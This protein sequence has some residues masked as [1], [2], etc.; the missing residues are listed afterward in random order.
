MEGQPTGDHQYFYNLDAYLH[1]VDEVRSWAS[2]CHRARHH[3]DRRFSKLR[4]FPTPAAP[5]IPR[6]MRKTFESY[7]DDSDAIRAFGLD[8]VTGCATSCSPRGLARPAFLQH[9]HGRPDHR[10]LPAT[11][12]D[13]LISGERGRGSSAPAVTLWLKAGACRP[14]I[15]HRPA[16][17]GRPPHLRRH[18]NPPPCESR[19][20]LPAPAV[21]SAGY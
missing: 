14:Q 1:F 5:R 20:S 12:A 13:C 17:F 19:S 11:G 2:R 16:I 6:W 4:V 10:D 9:E 21:A 18:P 3:A 8:V 7:G 15:L